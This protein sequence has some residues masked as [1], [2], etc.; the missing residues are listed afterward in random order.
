MINAP[1]QP[2][3]STLP[4]A[5]VSDWVGG[6]YWGVS[7]LLV[8]QG[9]P[10]QW[11][12]RADGEKVAG[13]HSLTQIAELQRARPSACIQISNVEH[14]GIP[15]PGQPWIQ[16]RPDTRLGQNLVRLNNAISVVAGG[17]LLGYVFRQNSG[18]WLP[19]VAWG[20]IC[21]AVFA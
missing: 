21:G 7:S 8:E 9:L 2:L 10:D 12:V 5:A 15:Q 19:R 14:D 16:V 18:G 11:R 3:G 6:L 1:S 13:T 20:L 4:A 17:L